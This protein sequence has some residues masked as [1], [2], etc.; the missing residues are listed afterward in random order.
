MTDKQ[1]TV[2]VSRELAERF[3]HGHPSMTD[4]NELRTLLAATPEQAVDVGEP[5]AWLDEESGAIVT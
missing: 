4:Q 5:V 1:S 3:C 2:V